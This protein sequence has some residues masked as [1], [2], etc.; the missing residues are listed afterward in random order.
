[1]TPSMER[2]LIELGVLSPTTIEA[3]EQVSQALTEQRRRMAKASLMT[4]AMKT[5]RFHSDDD[6]PT[7]MVPSS[8]RARCKVSPSE[9]T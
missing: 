5:E 9:Y 6:I 3:L 1:M 7:D 2:H 8:T 4:P